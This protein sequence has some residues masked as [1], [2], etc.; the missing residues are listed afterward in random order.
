MSQK[1]H[2]TSFTLESDPRDLYG[3]HER[4]DF[5]YDLSLIEKLRKSFEKQR[6][7]ERKV[8]LNLTPT[9]LRAE[10]PEGIQTKI[11]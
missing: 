10:I 7:V 9:S 11:L 4:Y 5:R 8:V 3:Y 2:K 1:K 6:Q